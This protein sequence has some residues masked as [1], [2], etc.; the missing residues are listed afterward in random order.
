MTW[1]PRYSWRTL[2]VVTVA[3][4]CA[5]GLVVRWHLRRVAAREIFP[6]AAGGDLERLK[7]CVSVR[8]GL[9][10]ARNANG[11]TPLLVAISPIGEEM[12]TFLVDSGADVS[13]ANASGRTP[14]HLAANFGMVA[15]GRLLIEHGAD[16]DAAAK[17]G[18]TPLH[19]AVRVGV[20][21]D[22]ADEREQVARLLLAA[23]ADI[24]RPDGRGLS[25]LHVIA[26][27]HFENDGLLRMCLE[28][29]AD[30][31]AKT[32]DGKTAA[33]LAEEIGHAALAKLIRGEATE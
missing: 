3:A 22:I 32:A 20:A 12:A 4:G 21:L 29:G 9:L 15:L 14:L 11:D 8:P 19:E 1:R 25:P 31:G 6:A 30:P 2:I 23:G 24:N 7:W 18:R 26:G 10:E 27:D 13:A 33:D 17:D 28:N 16:P 5:V